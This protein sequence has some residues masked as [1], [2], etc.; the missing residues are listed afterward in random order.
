MSTRNAISSAVRCALLGSGAKAVTIGCALFVVATS[1]SGQAQQGQAAEPGAPEEVVVTGS[2]I[3]RDTFNS[4]SPCRSSRAKRRTI[5]GFSSTTEA[6][7]GNAVTTGARAINNAFGGF[8]TDGGPGANTLSLR[9]LGAGPHVGAD[10]R[11]TRCPL[12]Y[13]R[14]GRL[15]GFERAA[16]R[17]HRP[18]RSPQDG[19]SSIYGSDAIA[20]VVNVV[21]LGDVEGLTFEAQYNDPLD[22]GGEQAAFPL[23][24]GLSGE[25]WT[26]GGSL[27][28]YDRER[29]DARRSRLDPVQRR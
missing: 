5:A 9:G 28:F 18:R 22:G 7:Q 20:G 8:V 21:T 12:W 27:E 23:V 6:L 10:Q 25:R 15:G 17:D 3:R 1:A 24:G 11:P 13:A 29:N 14:R 16:E 26:F 4:P 19:A 2:R